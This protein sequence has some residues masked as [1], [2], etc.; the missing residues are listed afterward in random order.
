MGVASL[1]IGGG[2]KLLIAPRMLIFIYFALG[3]L[4]VLFLYEMIRGARYYG[5]DNKISEKFGTSLFYFF[6]L[7]LIFIPPTTLGSNLLENMVSF[8]LS[9]KDFPEKISS[10]QR[11]MLNATEY[12]NVV[13]NMLIKAPTRFE[14]SKIRATGTYYKNDSLEKNKFFFLFGNVSAPTLNFLA[15]YDGNLT[16]FKNNEGVVVEGN[17]SIISI[18]D[19]NSVPLILV[20]NISKT[21]KQ[22]NN[23]TINL[24]D[25]RSPLANFFNTTDK[26]TYDKDFTFNFTE[27]N[28]AKYYYHIS[29]NLD[30]NLGGRVILRGF[31]YKNI[32]T[33]ESKESNGNQF[34]IGRYLMYCCVVDAVP[35]IFLAEYPRAEKL[36]NDQW[37]EVEGIINKASMKTSAGDSKIFPM[38][39]IDKLRVMG[40]S[41]NPYVYPIY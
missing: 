41:E 1:L 39:E 36:R 22:T 2:I 19:S 25:R 18:D 12:G 7:C 28:W 5:E 27:D 31:V 23:L 8:S 14:N 9:E 35:L 29:N 33:F 21:N 32:P 6:V 16:E 4:T 3:I 10:W 20:D 15:K 24:P 37:V 34:F 30:E 11:P 13:V 26:T 17:F 38:I 40:K